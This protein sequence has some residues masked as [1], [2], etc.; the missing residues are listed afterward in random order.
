MSLP[1][2]TP[3][4]TCQPVC[5]EH[6][7]DA[8]PVRRVGSLRLPVA[9]A[10]RPRATLWLFADGRRSWTVRLWEYDRPVRR[11]LPTPAVR[12]WAAASGLTTVLA[13]IDRL[14]RRAGRMAHGR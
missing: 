12:R 11:L 4:R 13:E 8:G 10:Y 2:G 7:D 9:G 3:N 5:D 6:L 14:D 1:N